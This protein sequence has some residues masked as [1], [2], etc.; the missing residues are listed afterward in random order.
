MSERAWLLFGTASAVVFASVIGYAIGE[1]VGRQRGVDFAET[2]LDQRVDEF[3]AGQEAEA[4]QD[5]SPGAAT[6]KMMTVGSSMSPSEILSRADGA[7]RDMVV[8]SSGLSPL[9]NEGRYTLHNDARVSYGTVIGKAFMHL[10]GPHDAALLGPFVVELPEE[11]I[12]LSKARVVAL[13][14][15]TRVVREGKIETGAPVTAVRAVNE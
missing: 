13:E 3:I 1:S 7:L 6:T 11:T 8:E 14:F 12:A 10:P 5:I 2:Y 9:A 4:A 15:E